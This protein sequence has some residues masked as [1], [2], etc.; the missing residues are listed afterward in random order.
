MVVVLNMKLLDIEVKIA[1]YQQTDI[2]L[3]NAIIS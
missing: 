2:V 1:L 3:L